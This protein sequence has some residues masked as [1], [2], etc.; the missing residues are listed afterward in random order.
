M[1]HKLFASFLICLHLTV[2][3][4]D[5]SSY[6]LV[7]FKDK[8]NSSFSIQNPEAFLSSKAISRRVKRNILIEEKDLPVNI[9]YLNGLR[10]EKSRVINSSKWLNAALISCKT[11]KDIEILKTLEY[12]KGYTY[13][14]RLENKKTSKVESIDNDYIELGKELQALKK[15]YTNANFSEKDY[16]KSFKQN[17]IIGIPG[18][19][20]KTGVMQ[21]FHIAVFDAGFRN[22][23]KVKGMEDLLTDNTIV[24]DFVDYDNS[25]WE[26]DQHG[27]NV[28]SFLKTFNPGNYIG[29]AP[30]AH[31]SLMRT[32][33]G[34]SE[35]KVEE[36]NWLLAAEFA[37][38]IGVDMIAA[39][40]GYHTFDETGLNYT[41][42]Q[43][44]GKTSIIAQAANEA[45]KRGILIVCSAGNEGSKPW[46]K[47]GTPADAASTIAIGSC[48]ETGFHSSFS[49]VGLSADNR[50]KPDF[51][52]PGYKVTVASVGGFYYGNGTSYAT[53]IFAGAM[54]NLLYL[55]PEKSF[56]E[57]KNAVRLS[58]THRELPDSAYGY[59]IPDFDLAAC[60]LGKCDSVNLLKDYFYMKYQAVM[61]QDLNIHFR[62]SVN[63]SIKITVL[64]S[65]GEKE[66]SIYRKRYS[67]KSGEWF[68]SDIVLQLSSSKKK[69]RMKK[70]FV[71]TLTIVFETENG[72]YRRSYS[73]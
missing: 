11:D 48:D 33:I 69:K 71:K 28:L 61:F 2:F 34:N 20:A 44:D 67:L 35:S 31:Y 72:V 73:F 1:Y 6:Y 66:K 43:L 37:D 25:V 14:G 46:R 38:S 36:V 15:S 65:N 62:S 10:S 23:Y 52:A 68:F 30:F 49:S 13:L 16:N 3:A 53:P 32:E 18:L 50:I 55:F 27:C 5:S 21:D 29:S 19:H 64:V 54:A 45:Y 70:S 60:M 56:E 39:S 63:Q 40:V 9:L 17:N 47:I 26:D 51:I 12:V 41:H 59:G 7:Y 24:R 42:K 22:A 58:A 4:E 8:N 57:L